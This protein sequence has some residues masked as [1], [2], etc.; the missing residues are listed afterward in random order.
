MMELPQKIGKAYAKAAERHR[1]IF[2]TI[3]GLLTAVFAVGAPTLETAGDP[4]AYLPRGNDEV[5][6][7]L[8]LNS[9]FGSLDAML[10]G[11]EEPSTAHPLE[12]LKHVFEITEALDNLKGQGVLAVRSIANVE[13]IVPDE[14]G[15]LHAG[16][17]ADVAPK[18]EE[19]REALAQRIRSNGIVA[20]ALISRNLKAYTVLVWPD[21]HK[22][23]RQTA[24]LIERTVE[25]LRGPLSA[26]YFGGPFVGNLVT[27]KVYGTL[28]W[29]IPLFAAVLIGSLLISGAALGRN[30]RE[31][32]LTIGIVLG[33][34]GACL[35][36]WL[37][38]VS[39]LG[40]TLGISDV[41][42][43]LL[44]F[45]LAVLIV[46]KYTSTRFSGGSL[47]PVS[48]P[49]FCAA[50]LFVLYF[51]GPLLPFPLPFLEHMSMLLALGLLACTLVGLLAV[52]P[53]LTFMSPNPASL[54]KSPKPTW[55]TLT[56][57]ALA[58]LLSLGGLKTRFVTSLEDL[59][60]GNEEIEGSVHFFQRNFGGSDFLQISAKGD[61]RA[62][63]ALARIYRLTDL[64][65]GI[66]EFADVRSISQVVAFVA[67]VFS[68]V[69][70]IP[71]D[72][73]ALNTLWFFLEG[74]ADIATLVTK[75]RD[76][77]MIAVRL[78]PGTDVQLAKNKI[79]GVIAES[80]NT[81]AN[82][83]MAR[84]RALARHFDFT[85]DGNREAEALRRLS[86][87][88]RIHEEALTRLREYMEGPE[89][90]FTPNAEEW[91]VL[92]RA[93][94]NA[95]VASLE[96]KSLLPL[97]EE[98]RTVKD[99]GLTKSEVLEVA[100]TLLTK[101]LFL[102]A[103]VRAEE[104]VKVLFGEQ[105]EVARQIALRVEGVFLDFLL[106]PHEPGDVRF[107]VTGY[108]LVARAAER[109]LQDG[110][111]RT[112]AAVIFAVLAALFFSSSR[113]TKRQVLFALPG[114]VLAAAVPYG[115][116]GLLAINVDFGSAA[117]ILCGPVA[118]GL[119]TCDRSSQARLS[120]VFAASVGASSLTLTLI[121]LLPVSRIGILLACSLATIVAVSHPFEK[122][123]LR[124]EV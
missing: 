85:V 77:A 40:W 38:M 9:R 83:V 122:G 116:S 30:A 15:T 1:P 98:L 70:R 69:S 47:P 20:G 99:L 117:V 49:I 100:H 16:R 59:F 28:P 79:E 89:A 31:K 19:E 103:K 22:D 94:G 29:L 76:E 107:F 5:A 37:G 90:P 115:L 92:S 105:G 63:S 62:P 41:N 2:L 45:V 39:L 73:A 110:L 12:G 95:D 60:V 81:D 87:R 68:G 64:L 66:E 53:L 14:E 86:L 114:L 25:T 57:I 3:A 50:S 52:W 11:L 48:F 46:A 13:T 58:S 102:D 18:T 124:R 34:A 61:M 78:A 118:S 4:A 80:A 121:G 111:L 55:V 112:L 54:L 108:P 36:W 123:Y 27:R 8:E 10:V 72:Q 67:Q 82:V 23:L 96:A 75:Q 56:A 24:T 91:A 101:A 93:L 26:Y 109:E 65:E 7:W 104:A 119:V 21:P 120:L 113:G 44:V 6:Q 74:N 32:V 43:L 35:V 88:E 106:G 84:L 51:L 33:S 42:A 71:E 97:L 17:L